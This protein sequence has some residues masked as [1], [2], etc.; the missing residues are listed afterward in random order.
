MLCLTDVL[1]LYI[2]IFL[3]ITIINLTCDQVN[4]L[5]LQNQIKPKF[6]IFSWENMKNIGIGKNS[7]GKNEKNFMKNLCKKGCVFDRINSL[8]HNFS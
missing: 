4:I 7:V 2:N 5:I 3:K 6:K 8:R 1:L